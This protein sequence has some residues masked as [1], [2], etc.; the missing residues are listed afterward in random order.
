M[1][2]ITKMPDI[3]KFLAVFKQRRRE[4]YGSAAQEVIDDIIVGIIE[5]KDIT[6]GSFPALEPE[7]IARK[8][9][10]HPL[11]NAGL[12]TQDH[13]Y[14]LNNQC[15]TDSAE[16]TVK[17]VTA[18]LVGID[19]KPVKMKTGNKTKTGKDQMA[20][21]RDTPRNE[22]AV[23]LQ[24]MG[25]NGKKWLFFGVSERASRKVMVIMDE[26]IMDSLNSL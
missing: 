5:E 1:I 2:T 24:E 26:V 25:I 11:I 19:G 23:I 14:R 4:F 6:G 20:T 13:T 7:T 8:G 10:N 21:L 3:G 15:R 18:P 9:H 16:V 12:L 17:P 22:V